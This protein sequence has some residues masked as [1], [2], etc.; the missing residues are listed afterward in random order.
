MIAF[1]NRSDIFHVW[2]KHC[3]AEYSIILD[4]RDFDAWQNGDAYIQE[5]LHYLTPAERELLIS[6]TCNECW[7]KFYD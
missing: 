5:A 4:E 7:E 2:C 3:G 6:E 1:N